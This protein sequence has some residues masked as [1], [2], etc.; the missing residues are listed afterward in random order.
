MKFI[1]WFFFLVS[2]LWRCFAPS[3]VIKNIIL[4]FSRNFILSNLWSVWNNFLCI[5]SGL[6]FTYVKINCP[7]IICWKYPF[8][9]KW[10]VAWFLINWS[11]N[12]ESFVEFYIV[13]FSI[14][15]QI[16]HLLDFSSSI[17][18]IETKQSKSSNYIHLFH[19][20]MSFSIQR[21]ST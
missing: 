3:K 14:F 19:V 13:L 10:F 21:T 4:F 17:V 6:C 5:I 1:S 11:Y 15:M 20:H 16:H 2:A 9:F 7:I 8:P 18:S 12:C